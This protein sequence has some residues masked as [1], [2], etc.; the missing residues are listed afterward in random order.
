MRVMSGTKIIVGLNGALQKRF[1][2]PES[3][4]LIP[5]D[6]HRARSVQT[7]V[8]GKGQ[9]AAIAMNCLSRDSGLKLAQFVG[10]GPSGDTVFDLLGEML[11]DP[12]M[13]LT[14]RT[15]KDIRICTSIVA[16][17]ETTELVEPSGLIEEEEM[18]ELL[19]KVDQIKDASA[20]CIMGSMPPG[21]SE[22][23][24]AEIYGLTAGSKTLCLVDSMSGLAPLIKKIASLDRPGPTVLKV[25]ASELCKLAGSSKSTS[26]TGGITMPELYEAIEMFKDKYSPFAEQALL[27]LC[28]TDGRHPGYYVSLS[29]DKV[30]MYKLP[31]PTLESN[32][33]LYP[34]G[35]GDCVAGGTLAAWLYL[36]G[37]KENNEVL[38]DSCIRVLQDRFKANSDG[39]DDPDLNAIVSAFSFGLACGSASK[40][41]I[42]KATLCLWKIQTSYTTYFLFC[43]ILL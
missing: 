14:V 28:I 33:P 31:I 4:T 30:S 36:T 39:I 6:V 32:G 9:D 5:G 25:N 37:E 10:M 2:L 42:S 35:A 1:V 24:Y 43:E 3:D 8:G 27:G 21:C 7:G 19:E 16:S 34:I 18:R 17:D 38:S 41:R 13:D 15:N 29:E 40:Y 22:D 26:E 20:L 23:T 11:G 12:A